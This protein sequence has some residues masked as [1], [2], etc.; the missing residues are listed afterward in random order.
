MVRSPGRVCRLT[1]PVALGVE[2]ECRE[3]KSEL[4]LEGPYEFVGVPAE[5]G[6]D[7]PFAKTVRRVIRDA[8]G[9]VLEIGARSGR[10]ITRAALRRGV[11]RGRRD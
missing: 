6:R 4:R 7:G 9:N 11:R 10:A 1:R 5:I 2:L 8:E 3:V